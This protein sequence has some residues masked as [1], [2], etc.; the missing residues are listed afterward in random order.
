MKFLLFFILITTVILGINASPIKLVRRLGAPKGWLSTMTYYQESAVKK[1][2]GVLGSKKSPTK[3]NEDSTAPL[4]IE[5][6][7][8]GYFAE[9]IVGNQKFNVLMDTGSSNL[10]VPTKNCDSP[11]CDN[12]NIYDSAKS[13]TF[14]EDGVP[15]SITYGI[16]FASGVTGKDDVTIAGLTA[17]QLLFGLASNVSDDSVNQ[18]FDG[19]CGLAFD[20]LNTMEGSPTLVSTLINQNKINPLFGIHLSRSADFDDIG[21]FT[22][23]G[24]DNSKFK[25]DITFNNIINDTGFW[26]IAVDDILV[27]NKPIGFAGKDAIIDT[28]TTLNLLPPNDAAAV[29]SQ[30]PGSTTVDNFYIIPCDTNSTVAFKFNGATFQMSSQDLIFMPIGGNQCVTSIVPGEVDGPNTWLIGAAFLKNVYSVFD[31]KNT[32]VGFAN[33]S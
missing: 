7:D 14:N 23:G 31:V 18:V 9:I 6:K 4:K 2:S 26:Q 1:Y 19:I 5:D 20:K 3:R 33:L 16:G 30:I 27:D 24:V 25:G 11:A 28:G 12:H 8:V 13:K 17:N 15:W 22:L 10:W 29:N 21:T 32:S